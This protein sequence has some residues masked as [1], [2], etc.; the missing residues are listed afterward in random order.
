MKGCVEELDH[1]DDLIF[2]ATEKRYFEKKTK[3]GEEK[4][5]TVE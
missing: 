5:S 3:P 2:D 1:L 4:I